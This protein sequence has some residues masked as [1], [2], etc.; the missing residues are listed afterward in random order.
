MEDLFDPVIAEITSLV[1]KQVKAAK[2]SKDA[3]INVCLDSN[4]EQN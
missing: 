4:S 2:T 1:G 3:E